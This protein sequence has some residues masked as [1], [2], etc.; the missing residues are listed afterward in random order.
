[1][2]A[3]NVRNFI[4]NLPKSTQM[5]IGIIGI[6]TATLHTSNI[7]ATTAIRSGMKL[8]FQLIPTIW[9]K[10]QFPN[11]NSGF[12]CVTMPVIRPVIRLVIQPVIRLVIRLAI[13]L[14]QR[15]RRFI[16][17]RRRIRGGK[18]DEIFSPYTNTIACANNPIARKQPTILHGLTN[19]LPTSNPYIFCTR[20]GS[21]PD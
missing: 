10:G 7:T 19:L 1:M 8:R 16:R 20:R 18:C 15:R 2:N 6:T 9:C 3:N 12:K 4:P 11:N 21:A 13:R 5:K 14:C 17:R